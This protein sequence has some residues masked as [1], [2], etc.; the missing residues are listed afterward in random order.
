MKAALI[1]GENVTQVVW[2][3]EHWRQG[4]KE[5]RERLQVRGERGASVSPRFHPF[6]AAKIGKIKMQQKDESP[7]NGNLTFGT[8]TPSLPLDLI[9]KVVK[10]TEQSGGSKSHDLQWRRPNNYNRTWRRNKSPLLKDWRLLTVAGAPALLQP[11]GFSAASLC[12]AGDH[13]SYFYSSRIY[14]P[15]SNVRIGTVTGP[16]AYWWWEPTGEI[17]FDQWQLSQ[18]YIQYIYVYK[19]A[20]WVGILSLIDL[21]DIILFVGDEV[22]SPLALQPV[23]VTPQLGTHKADK[24]I[25]MSLFG[26]MY[27]VFFCVS[28]VQWKWL[29]VQDKVTFLW[30]AVRGTGGFIWGLISDQ[31]WSWCS[32]FW[33]FFRLCSAL[34]V[35]LFNSLS[36]V[37]IP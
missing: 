2:T 29:W 5:T 10:N 19:W 32:G 6:Q 3:R 13:G 12:N 23:G 33:W 7:Q 21:S 36:I 18:L 27:F 28:I 34:C 25:Q 15:I 11:L 9:W 4:E 37:E 14:L 1:H 31:F 20:K 8:E 17:H 35:L 30:C 22:I 16:A 24:L 26:E